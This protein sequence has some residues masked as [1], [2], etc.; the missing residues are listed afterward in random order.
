MKKLRINPLAKK[1]IMEIQNYISKELSNSKAAG[2]VITKFFEAFDTLKEFPN[3]GLE[4]S[5]KFNI[6]N[7]YR[8]VNSENYIVFY[9]IGDKFISIYRILYNKRD[10][11]NILF[12]D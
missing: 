2:K 10:F 4:L 3:L 8:Y 1:D 9:R 11:K 6:K 12:K 7:D 5:T